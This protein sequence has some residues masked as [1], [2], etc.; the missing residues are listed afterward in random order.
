VLS[1]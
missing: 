1:F